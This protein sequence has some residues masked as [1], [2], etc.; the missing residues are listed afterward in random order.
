M[1]CKADRGRRVEDREGVDDEPELLV[2][3]EAVGEDEGEAG[4]GED[5]RPLVQ[6]ADRHQEDGGA[7]GP[8]EGAKSGP[9]GPVW[10]VRPPFCMF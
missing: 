5:G 4:E 2:G 9:E 8:G 10:P 1:T 3:E 7:Q 6:E